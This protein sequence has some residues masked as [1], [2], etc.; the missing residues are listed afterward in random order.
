M[1]AYTNW[2]ASHLWPSIVATM[3]KQG[4]L[5]SVLSPKNLS[6]KAKKS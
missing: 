5:T 2:F 3:K 6:Q 4:D 1:N